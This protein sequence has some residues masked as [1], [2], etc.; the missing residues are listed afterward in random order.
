LLCRVCSLMNRCRACH[1][2]IPT[3]QGVRSHLSQKKSC[4]D[5]I[6]AERLRK[7]SPQESSVQPSDQMDIDDPLWIP[8]IP[9]LPDE[10]DEPVPFLSDSNLQ[11]SEK[12][13]EYFPTK[14][15]KTHGRCT[16]SYERIRR[17]QQKYG[18]PPWAPFNSHGEWE[19]AKWLATSGA[20]HKKIDSLLKLETVSHCL[21]SMKDSRAHLSPPIDSRGHQALVPHGT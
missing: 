11:S 18:E 10:P 21:S 3:L 4:R 12:F 9:L 7:N 6:R 19:F 2:L 17:D 5:R 20:S 15:S 14:V 1:R 13:V 8:D 16:S